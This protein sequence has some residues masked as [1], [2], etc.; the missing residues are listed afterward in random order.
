[1]HLKVK[2]SPG[3]LVHNLYKFQKK[4][5]IFLGVWNIYNSITWNYLYTV[6]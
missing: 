5:F 4:M 2:I 3:F 6:I 1:M